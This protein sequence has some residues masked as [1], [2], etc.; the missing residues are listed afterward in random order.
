MSYDDVEIE[1]MEWN[2]DL[3]AFTYPCPCGDLFQITRAELQMGE[4]ITH[5]PSCSL[6]IT[7]V[8]TSFSGGE[9]STQSSS[10][11][12]RISPRSLQVA[13]IDHKYPT[14]SSEHLHTGSYSTQ[15]TTQN[16][17]TQAQNKTRAKTPRSI[18]TISLTKHMG[19]ILF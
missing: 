16:I 2:E 13:G 12:I 1:D 17:S 6:Y 14:Q 7:V 5:Y 11:R 10:R 4:E 18:T 3:Q 15:N 8:S 9:V 19:N